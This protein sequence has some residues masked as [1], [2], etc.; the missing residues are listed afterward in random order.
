M[1]CAGNEEGG[2]PSTGFLEGLRH[3][4]GGQRNGGHPWTHQDSGTQR[5]IVCSSS[6]SDIL[7]WEVQEHWPGNNWYSDDYPWW[8]GVNGFW[9]RPSNWWNIFVAHIA[10]QEGRYCGTEAP[11]QQ[12]QLPD[13]SDTEGV[14]LSLCTEGGAAIKSPSVLRASPK[15]RGGRKPPPAWS[16]ARA[17]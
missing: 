14:D 3:L 12:C 13:R 9:P 8:E 4:P 11:R 10:V 17:S 6:C 15:R 16:H 5:S 7:S 2:W 1:I